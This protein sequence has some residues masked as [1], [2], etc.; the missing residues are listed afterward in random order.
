MQR[1]VDGVRRLSQ[2]VGVDVDLPVVPGAFPGLMVNTTSVDDVAR[3]VAPNVA[4]TG[5]VEKGSLLQYVKFQ[6]MEQVYACPDPT[7]GPA[8][9]ES[10]G[11]MPACYL[12]NASWTPE[13]GTYGLHGAAGCGW[14]RD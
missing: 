5:Q 10:L 14:Q 3:R 4:R 11:Q 7:T 6:G 8:W 1:L 13:E 12:F 2:A 9:N